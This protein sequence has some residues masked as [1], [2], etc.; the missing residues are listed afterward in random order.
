M[1]SLVNPGQTMLPVKGR[2]LQ[3]TDKLREAFLFWLPN[4][5]GIF[6]ISFANLKNSLQIAWGNLQCSYQLLQYSNANKLHFKFS[7]LPVLIS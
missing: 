7:Q 5:F 4:S 3:L 1:I 6:F 2:D